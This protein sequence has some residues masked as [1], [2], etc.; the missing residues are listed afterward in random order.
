VGVRCLV[1]FTLTAREQGGWLR[2]V[3]RLSDGPVSMRSAACVLGSAAVESDLP[4]LLVLLRPTGR[5]TRTT[6]SRRKATQPL[7]LKLMFMFC[8]SQ[9]GCSKSH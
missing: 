5:G 4:R 8:A 7:M 9:L 1:C 2:E 6:D 3:I